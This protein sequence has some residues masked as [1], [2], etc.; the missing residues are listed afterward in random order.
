MILNP[1]RKVL[2]TFQANRVQCLLMGGQ[3]CILYGAAEFSR[4]SDFAVMADAGNLMR[5][6]KSL[7]ALDAHVIAVP[8]FKIEYLRRGHAV[9]F[10]C[11]REDVRGMRIDIMSEMR[12]V[13]QFEELWERR[14]TVE[15]PDGLRVEVMGLTDLVAAKKTQRDKDWQMLRR[16]MEADCFSGREPDQDRIVFWLR[17]LRTASCLSDTVSRF[18]D[19]AGIVAKDRQAVSLALRGEFEL[20]EQALKEEEAAE[21]KADAEYWKPLRRELESL[22]H[23]LR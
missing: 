7:E 5:I 11:M 21:K 19:E 17:E 18:P 3:A 6:Q 12:G 16:L 13:A 15:L 23:G 2:F 4:D 22:R 10:R 1:I 20:V 9:H 8:P 14:T